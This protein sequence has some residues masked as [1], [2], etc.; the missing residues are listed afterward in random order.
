M[1]LETGK[2]DLLQEVRDIGEMIRNFMSVKA[3]KML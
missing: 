2:F 3:A 1:E